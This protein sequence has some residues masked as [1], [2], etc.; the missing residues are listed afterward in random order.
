MTETQ[1]N[2]VLEILFRHGITIAE[3]RLENPCQKDHCIYE[4]DFGNVCLPTSL[5]K[6]W[7]T[8]RPL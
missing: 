2:D 5:A 8:V 3:H 4:S 7:V 6:D 1:F